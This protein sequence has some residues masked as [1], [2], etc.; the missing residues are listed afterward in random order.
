MWTYCV[1]RALRWSAAT[2]GSLYRI[3]LEPD[4]EQGRSMSVVMGCANNGM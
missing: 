2:G 3:P 4:R 1:Q